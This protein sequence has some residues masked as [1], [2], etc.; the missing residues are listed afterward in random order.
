MTA[1][2]ATTPARPGPPARVDLTKFALLSVAAAV[3]TI[4]LKVYAWRIT[5]S[6]GLL[7]DAAESVV[8]LVAAVTALFA[9]RVAARPED[10]NHHFGHAKAEYFSA[11]IEGQMIFIAACV[12]IWTAVQRLLHPAPIESVGIGLAVS[13]VAS[14][15]NGACALVLLR[16]GREQGLEAGARLKTFIMQETGG[17][18]KTIEAGVAAVCDRLGPDPLDPAADPDPG[19]RDLDVPPGRRADADERTLVGLVRRLVLGE[20]HVAVRAEDLRGSELVGEI[21]DHIFAES[22]AKDRPDRRR[23]FGPDDLALGGMDFVHATKLAKDAIQLIELDQAVNLP[24]AIAI[25]NRNLDKA[26]EG[27]MRSV[28][29][30][31]GQVCLGT[32]RVYVERPIFDDFTAAV[33]EAAS[34]AKIGPGLDP[35]TE[36]GPLVSQEQFDRVSGYLSAGL[37]DGARALTGGKRWGEEGFFIEPTVF[38]DVDPSF[39]IVEE[40][41]FGPVVA[42]MPFDAEDGVAAAANNSI[43]GLAAGIWTQ[44]LSKAHRTARQIQAGSVWVN[45]YNGFDTALPFG[46]FKQ[47]GNGRELGPTGLAEYQE[48]K[49][50]YQNLSPAAW[51]QFGLQ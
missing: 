32:E 37:A 44:D 12:I 41:I 47:S 1:V 16:A 18:R 24:V 19:G 28:F 46:G 38:V 22:N 42:A 35:S 2:P 7:S 11:A 36:L 33:A 6:V 27:T 39:S 50:V 49:H 5:G 25:I 13:V 8:N 14:L 31:C 43:Y 20:A 40:E 4:A 26:I 17:T 9:L 34:Q 3:V 15:I 30:N 48:H 51:D 23:L 29:A 21:V 10:K 45:Q